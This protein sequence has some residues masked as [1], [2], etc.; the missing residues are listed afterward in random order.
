M[1]KKMRLIAS[2]RMRKIKA[3]ST[4]VDV[5]DKNRWVADVPLYKKN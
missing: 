4:H 2:G 5:A 1:V 3:T